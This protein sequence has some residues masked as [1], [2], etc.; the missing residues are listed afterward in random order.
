LEERELQNLGSNPSLSIIDLIEE[1]KNECFWKQ[2]HM[3][4]SISLYLFLQL[5]EVNTQI[6]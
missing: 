1:E 5:A 3:H 6:P 4:L 2:T